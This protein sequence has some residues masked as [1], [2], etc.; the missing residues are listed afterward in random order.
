MKVIKKDNIQ[1]EEAHDGAGKRKLFVEEDEFKNIQGITRGYLPVGKT[2]EWHKHDDCNEFMYVLKGNGVVRD[3]NGEYPFTT[4]DFYIFPKGVFHE[5][6]NTGNE[7]IEFVFIRV[8][9]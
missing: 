2:F 8:K 7:Q 1:I 6:I 9:E 5:Q 4:G 3:E